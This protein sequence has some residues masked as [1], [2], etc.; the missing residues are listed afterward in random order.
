[1]RVAPGLSVAAIGEIRV[2]LRPRTADNLPVLGGVPGVEGIYLTTGHGA[3]GLQLG[4]LSG[5][6]AAEW[7]AGYD[8][9]I[10]ISLFSVTRFPENQK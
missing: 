1:M 8:S 4:P 10:D 7:A 2:G 3:N 5:K 9:K 6:L